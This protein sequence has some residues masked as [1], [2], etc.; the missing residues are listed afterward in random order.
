MR[1]KTLFI[2]TLTFVLFVFLSC[3]D[4]NNTGTG[5]E[6]N[7]TELEGT[8]IGSDSFYPASILVT[9]IFSGNNWDFTTSEQSEWFKGAFT[10]N[11]STN[12]KQVDAK[13][14]ES[15]ETESIGKTSL[16]IYKIE[17]N[18]VTFAVNE[19]GIITRPSSFTSS[20]EIRVWV[21]IKQ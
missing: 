14:N 15:S 12:P 4:D 13:I 9:F 19:P 2:L 3:S 10:L 5:P 17:D 7:V 8:W 20:A 21:L 1:T 16:G 18:T 11:T 6:G